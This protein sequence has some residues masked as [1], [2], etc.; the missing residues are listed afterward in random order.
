[1]T[2]RTGDSSD[3]RRSDLEGR[4]FKLPNFPKQVYSCHYAGWDDQWSI[5]NK[6]GQYQFSVGGTDIIRS[7]YLF[8]PEKKKKEKYKFIPIPYPRE[9]PVKTGD[10]IAGEIFEA[11]WTI[12]KEIAYYALLFFVVFLVGKGGRDLA[13][14]I[15]TKRFG[16][17]YFSSD[18][19]EDE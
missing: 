3:A 17:S 11:I 4:Q 12:E 10:Q 18:T 9:K 15:E 7:G 8:P 6:E 16:K 19:G 13:D 1:M 2:Y 5:N 14:K